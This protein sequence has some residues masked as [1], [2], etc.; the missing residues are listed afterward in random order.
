MGEEIHCARCGEL[1]PLEGHIDD[2]VGWECT[3]CVDKPD[4]FYRC[5][6]RTRSGMF[7]QYDGHIDV[8]ARSTSHAAMHRA[9]VR[10]LRLS[11]FP[12]YGSDVWILERWEPMP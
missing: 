3:D 6:V 4:S 10:A 2:S 9:A 1:F 11:A 5:Y 12:D 7:A 8:R